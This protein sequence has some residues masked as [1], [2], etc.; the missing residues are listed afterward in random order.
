MENLTPPDTYKEPWTQTGVVSLAD[1]SRPRGAA[2]GH[3][4]EVAAEASPSF[5]ELAST[6]LFSP[7]DGRI[8]LHRSRAL[9]LQASSFG[10]L[11]SAL[12]TASGIQEAKKILMRIGY[13][14]GQRDAELIRERWPDVPITAQFAAGPRIWTL[15][16]LSKVTTLRFEFDAATRTF[17]GDFLIHDSIEADEYVALGITNQPGCWWSA[18][19]ASGYTSGI[20]GAAVEYQEVECR[21]MGHSYCRLVAGQDRRSFQQ[22]V[23]TAPAELPAGV[24]ETSKDAPA[25]IGQ[26]SSFRAA[27]D[28]L[29]KVAPTSATVLLHGE[30]GTGKE[31]FANALHTL[32]TRHAGPFVAINCA[33]I[34]ETLAES[35][36]FGVER[37]AY[38]GAVATRPGRFE[39]ASGG[40][41]FLD[42]VASLS[43]AAQ[44][45]LLR[46][47]QERV[48]ER[49]GGMRSIPVDVRLVVASNVKLADEVREGRFREDLYF[50]LNVFPITLPPLRERRDDIP[51]LM[52]FFLQTY[53]ARHD[54]SLK[55]FTSAA[56]DLLLHYRYPGNVRELQN[57]IERGVICAD[58]GDWLDKAHIFRG[59]EV[60]PEKT[61]LIVDVQGRLTTVGA[62]AAP[63][64]TR[65]LPQDMPDPATSLLQSGH[66]LDDVERLMCKQ[67]LVACDG[68]L[69]AAAR[70]LGV[71]RARLEHRA[72]QW[73][74]VKVRPRPNAGN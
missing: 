54:K 20:L 26:S 35:E 60:L 31:M 7:S 72:K 28:L 66:T 17:S 59:G 53:C 24:S 5:N 49:V 68:N 15:Q 32:S 61:G 48:L 33:A 51:H 64:P 16:G 12:V 71:S 29:A 41:L 18:G 8:W 42:E 40:T 4:D 73:G 74:L 69:S 44:A 6:L 25:M 22:L 9:I 11:R 30:S 27:R 34:P 38:T 57:L 70:K 55:G 21:C 14:H 19:Y 58:E 52:Q 63:P 10:D 36:L 47:L 45:K 2:R 43:A 37:G 65:P 56:K 13:T 62:D 3:S 50:R 39:R 1:A 67:A 23:S 46:V